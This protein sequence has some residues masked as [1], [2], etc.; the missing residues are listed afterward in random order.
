MQL[1]TCRARS[2]SLRGKFR[3]IREIAMIFW[4]DCALHF[5]LNKSFYLLKS[6]TQIQSIALAIL[7]QHLTSRSPHQRNNADIQKKAFYSHLICVDAESDKE[8]TFYI[9]EHII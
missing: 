1:L 7:A 5:D 4:H 8:F 3:V 6:G 9:Q 2:L